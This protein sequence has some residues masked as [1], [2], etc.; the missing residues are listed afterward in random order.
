MSP[1]V[2]SVA[3][4]QKEN[5]FRNDRTAV[6]VA[7]FLFFPPLPT[8]F[9]KMD[10]PRPPNSPS[11]NLTLDKIQILNLFKLFDNLPFDP[12]SENETW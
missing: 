3:C 11:K 1:R 2:V 6:T 7:A 8:N 9:A 4:E 5:P 10:S 12:K